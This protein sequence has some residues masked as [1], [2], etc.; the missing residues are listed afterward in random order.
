MQFAFAYVGFTI[1]FGFLMIFAPRLTLMLCLAA[2]LPYLTTWSASLI[3]LSAILILVGGI[4]GL[5]LDIG[6]WARAT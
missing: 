1:V 3:I 2:F 4:L 5:L 6:S